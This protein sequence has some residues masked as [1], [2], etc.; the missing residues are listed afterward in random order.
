MFDEL[1]RGPGQRRRRNRL[2]RFLNTPY[3]IACGIHIDSQLKY[4]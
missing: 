1:V 3:S 2:L 4:L